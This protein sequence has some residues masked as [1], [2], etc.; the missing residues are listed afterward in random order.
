MCNDQV[1]ALTD[2]IQKSDIVFAS[3]TLVLC[4]KIGIGDDALKKA[5]I[6]KIEEGAES[7]SDA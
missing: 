2:L 3:R 6:D 1:P 7:V 4:E 5:C